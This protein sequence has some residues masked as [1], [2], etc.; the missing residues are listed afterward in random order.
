MSFSARLVFALLG[1]ALLLVSRGALADSDGDYCIGKRY[2]AY[3][4]SF[5]K[6]PSDQHILTIVWFKDED[7]DIST[8]DLRLEDFQVHHIKCLDEAIEIL[9]FDTLYRVDLTGGGDGLAITKT[10]LEGDINTLT[11]ANPAAY[12]ETQ[13][14]GELY[15]EC[16]HIDELTTD[17][18]ITTLSP[19]DYQH[20]YSL[21]IYCYVEMEDRGNYKEAYHYVHSQV[22]K[23]SGDRITEIF[24]IYSGGGRL[25]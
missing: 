18:T 7:G 24:D 5:S 10:P 11:E 6:A 20:R 1:G 4:F 2:L 17:P 23:K 22:V 13:N 21:H 15:R 8:T 12:S 16:K 14:L 25:Y 9:S 19:P 3:Q